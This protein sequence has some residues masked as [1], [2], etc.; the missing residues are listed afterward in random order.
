MQVQG[1]PGPIIVCTR[2]DDLQGVVDATP[3]D[4][5]KDL[6][7]TQNGMLQ[8]W[9]DARGLGDNTQVRGST[10]RAAQLSKNKHAERR[11]KYCRHA[12]PLYLLSGRVVAKL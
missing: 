3:E 8:P 7:F 2:N 4:R 6:V 1:P 10:D 9:L 12:A 5:S 11:I